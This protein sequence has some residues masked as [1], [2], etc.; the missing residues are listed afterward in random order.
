MSE[1]EFLRNVT[2]GQYL[3]GDS[4]L[5]RLDPRARLVM[6][7]VLVIGVLLDRSLLGL[8]G[9]L[10]AVAGGLAMANISLRYAARGLRPAIPFLVLLSLW[11]LFSARG[12]GQVLWQWRWLTLTTAGLHAATSTALRFVVLI[13]AL[14]L[15]SFITATGELTHGV[16]HLLRPLQRFGFPAHELALSLLIALRFI[17]LL[18]REAERIAKAQASRGGDTGIKRTLHLLSLIVPLFIAALRRAER[19]TLAMEARCYTGGAGRT[20][21]IQLK[22]D[23]RDAL[24][25]ATVLAL[26][27]AMLTATWLGLP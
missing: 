5:H 11:Q 8:I 23:R 17:P 16:E 13:L 27:V 6:A 22:A 12:D 3:P 10:G 21:L 25:V 18:A 14:S 26:T 20:H 15:F 7:A 19:L 4:P 24:A 1:F 2:I 9:A